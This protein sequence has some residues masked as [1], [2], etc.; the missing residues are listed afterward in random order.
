VGSARQI[1][2][3]FLPDVSHLGVCFTGGVCWSEKGDYNRLLLDHNT[4]VRQQVISSD[5]PATKQQD[6]AT[7]DT[8]KGER[9]WYEN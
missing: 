6:F 5:E 7:I 1:P 8:W 9:S 3:T 4:I 2:L